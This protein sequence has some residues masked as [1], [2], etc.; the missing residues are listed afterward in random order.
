MVEVCSGK[1][2]YSLP[3]REFKSEADIVS[4]RVYVA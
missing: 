1:K 3:I 2:K 4:T